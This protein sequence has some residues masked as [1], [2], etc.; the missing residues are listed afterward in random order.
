VDTLSETQDPRALTARVEPIRF[1]EDRRIAVCSSND[2]LHHRP[3]WKVGPVDRSVSECQSN[4]RMS[5]R[6]Q[7]DHLFYDRSRQRSVVAEARP[8]VLVSGKAQEGQGD[9]AVGGVVPGEEKVGHRRD[10]LG[11]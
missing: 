10:E 2:G 3:D 7:S 1:D 4:G 9:L 8:D 5:D 6:L 11:G